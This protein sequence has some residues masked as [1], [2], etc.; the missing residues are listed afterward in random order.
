M[1]SMAE[2]YEA[3]G[4][5]LIEKQHVRFAQIWNE[6]VILS[7]FKMVWLSPFPRKVIRQTVGTILAFYCWEDLC[8]RPCMLPLRHC[9]RGPSKVW[10]WFQTSMRD[11]WHD[12]LSMSDLGKV[13][14][15]DLYMAFIDLTKAFDSIHRSALWKM[16][17]KIGCPEKYIRTVWLLHDN[18]STS[19][20][21]D[22][23]S[24]KSFEVK[25]GVKQGCVV[26]PSRFSSQLC[27]TWVWRNKLVV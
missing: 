20:L 15:T 3:A 23:E 8:L 26:D 25:T 19:A 14:R 5:A 27:C 21:I 16:L 24:T 12:F 18:M 22:A 4:R 10:M 1:V 13:Q 2:V 7:N 6:E 11:C 17:S 9:Q